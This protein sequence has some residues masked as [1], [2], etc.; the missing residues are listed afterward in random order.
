MARP[1]RSAPEWWRVGYHASPLGFTPLVR[2]KWRNRFD[3]LLRRYRTLYFAVDQATCLRETLQDLR[4]T[5]ATILRLKDQG[6]PDGAI[7]RPVV[8]WQ[9]RRENVLAPAGLSFDGPIA[10]LLDPGLRHDLEHDLTNLLHEHG[11]EHLDATQLTS[12]NR[13]VA[14]AISH[15]LFH[16]GY[17]GIL[18]RS[19][20]DLQLCLALFEGRGRPDAEGDVVPLTND[21]AA[22]DTVCAEF[23][24]TLEGAPSTS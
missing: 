4:L 12:V 23:G 16:Q 7:P 9:F 3:D 11:M 1:S 17:A 14:Q 24:L 6:I 20:L 22:L 18:F 5:P 13:A 19:N 8:S 10:D 21:V 15:T 2:Y